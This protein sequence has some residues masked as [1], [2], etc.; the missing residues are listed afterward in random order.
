MIPVRSKSSIAFAAS[1]NPSIL[2]KP[3]NSFFGRSIMRYSKS[4]RTVIRPCLIP[5]MILSPRLPSVLLK[6]SMNPITKSTRP[7]TIAMAA[8][9]GQNNEPRPVSNGPI[10]AVN[11]PI[12]FVIAEIP[13]IT[14]IT[15]VT[16]P[17]TLPNIPPNNAPGSTAPTLFNAAFNL[18]GSFPG[19]LA[20]AVFSSP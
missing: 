16:K 1:S 18:L 7:T 13:S 20:S 19:V 9:M 10:S 17:P 8:V 15:V 3:D 11:G 6:P 5:P 4:S 2:I 14:P 12:N